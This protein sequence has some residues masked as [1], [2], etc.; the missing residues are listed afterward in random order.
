M[1]HHPR[2]SL[3]LIALVAIVA[4]VLTA[5]TQPVE[6]PPSEPASEA[7]TTAAPTP[8]PTATP[9]TD[10]E[11][12]T[13]WEPPVDVARLRRTAP[14]VSEPW[15][16]GVDPDPDRGH[17]VCADAKGPKTRT[18][19]TFARPD[20]S[21]T[22]TS[23]ITSLICAAA[24]KATLKIAI[25]YIE[26]DGPDVQQILDA[27]SFVQARRGVAIRIVAD[28]R[29]ADETAVF[30]STADQLRRIAS[31]QNCLD[32]CR[33]ELPPRGEDGGSPQVEVQHHK[34]MVLSDTFA[35]RGV[36]PMVWMASG[37]WAN[38]QLHVRSQSGFILRDPGLA[39]AFTA[40]FDS[41]YACAKR[42]CRAWNRIVRQ[43]KLPLAVYG[44][45]RKG[46]VWFDRTERAWRGSPGHGSSVVFSPWHSKDPLAQQLRSMRC[47]G[48][49]DT[50]WMAQRVVARSRGAVT[51]RLAALA[52]QGCDV[53]VLVSA[54]SM[55]QFLVFRDGYRHLRELG[56][57][58]SCV[59]GVH[60]KFF[61]I[62]AVN[63]RT[64]KSTRSIT[65]GTQGL[66]VRALKYSDEAMV[67]LTTTGTTGKAR[68]A[69]QKVWLAYADH[70]RELASR[71]E[72]CPS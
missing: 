55:R 59:E 3:R 58:V 41:L 39:A 12:P 70:F 47:S 45:V 18:S 25:Y 15:P 27:L 35:S 43:R 69:N 20:G 64:G 28:R 13:P 16:W 60:D 23:G 42:G 8:T 37:N 68:R 40:R 24:P 48:K 52:N 33:S 67:T 36:A 63:R 31:V 4:I 38:R 51:R 34:F 6:A 26:N 7:P 62:D 44:I 72:T 30:T 10:A 5:C 66:M 61:L 22:L 49:H 21:A 50:I 56:L 71:P 2:R 57:D 17:R 29:R 46:G 11:R 54:S 32:G 53:R 1:D 65:A 14:T 19:A 9:Q